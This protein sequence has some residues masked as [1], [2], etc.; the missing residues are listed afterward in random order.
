MI[1]FSGSSKV[2]DFGVFADLWMTT[3]S[4][5]ILRAILSQARIYSLKMYSYWESDGSGHGEAMSLS[6]V[7][8][9]E[10]LCRRLIPGSVL[11]D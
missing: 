2:R 4:D 1:K 9:W 10:K 11:R 6:I 5:E 8:D 7:R 3:M